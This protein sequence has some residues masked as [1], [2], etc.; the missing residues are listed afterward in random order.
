MLKIKYNVKFNFTLP[1]KNF[2]QCTLISV[3]LTLGVGCSSANENLI[4]KPVSNE[5]PLKGPYEIA[6][7]QS[8][9]S[10]VSYQAPEDSL[11]FINEPIFKFN[12][13]VYRYVLS[14]LANGYEKVVPEPIDNS[15]RNFFYNLREPL[16]AINHLL[17]GE[18]SA[19]GKSV[20]RVLINSTVGLL[21]LFDAA[22][23]LMDLERN[24]TTFGET[25][26][27]YGVGHGAYL[28]LPLLGP[29]D[30]RDTASL[31]FNY[32][33]H[34]LNFINDEDAATQLLLADGIQAQIPILAK[35]PDVI[36]DIENPYEFVRNLYMQNILRDGQ[37]RRNEIFKTEKQ[38][39]PISKPNKTI[40]PVVE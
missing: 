36:A 1:H 22:N 40:N 39:K 31:T 10:V 37:A 2:L 15:I 16:Y 17:Q 34:P 18:F 23:G 13:T 9:P 8:Q 19:S 12:D 11:R 28:V 3:L 29:S 27:T 7:E 14:P 20:S 38:K 5:Q 6:A 26:A 35:Y 32:F 33:V 4:E 24:K 21:G 30:L 25:L